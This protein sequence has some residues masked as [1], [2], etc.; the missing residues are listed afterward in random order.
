MY[1]I[2]YKEKEHTMK[3]KETFTKEELEVVAQWLLNKSEKALRER[4]RENADELLQL[5]ELELTFKERD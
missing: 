4:T 3:T 2:L 5:A 1:N